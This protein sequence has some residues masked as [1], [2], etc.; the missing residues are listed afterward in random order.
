MDSRS[1]DSNGQ[2]NT[3]GEQTDYIS[4]G[5]G[6]KNLIII[7]GVGDGLK[8]VKGM[9][10]PFAFLYR[11]LAKDFKVYVFS[12]PVKQSNGGPIKT[13]KSLQSRHTCDI[14]ITEGDID[15]IF[16]FEEVSDEDIKDK[17]KRTSIVQESV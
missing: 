12:R 13:K 14:M 15:D 8:T 16:V 2:I 17:G 11:E 4:F 3:N 9:A 1:H 7:P 10:L 6:D 5:K